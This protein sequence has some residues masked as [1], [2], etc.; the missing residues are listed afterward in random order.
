MGADGRGPGG[1]DGSLADQAYEA[2]LTRIADGTYPARLPAEARLSAE[3][4]VSRPV[5]RRAL[6]RL[7]EDGVIRSRQGS[8]SYVE[9]RPDRAVLRFAALGSIADIRRVFEFRR[10]VEGDA[11]ALAAA[12]RTEEGLSAMRAA[13][14]RLDRCIEEGLLGSEEDAAFH[15]A[16][17]ASAGNHYYEAALRG[18]ASQVL[19]GMTLARSLSLTHPAERL[20]L[21]QDEHRAVLAAIEACDAPG[22]REAMRAHVEAARTR[23]FEGAPEEVS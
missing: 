4:G 15:R 12:R 1:R 2:V 11:A 10:S 6:G 22:A 19:A 21:V 17:A 18:M 16:V 23:M 20:R 3:L 5:L 14:S 8:G 9:R 7:R 13:L